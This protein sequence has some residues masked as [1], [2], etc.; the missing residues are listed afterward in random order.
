MYFRTL[1]TLLPAVN[2]FVRFL[3][4]CYS[5]SYFPCTPTFVEG[6]LWE[7][8]LSPSAPVPDVPDACPFL[9][10]M[11]VLSYLSYR[12]PTG[13]PFLPW[14]ACPFLSLSSPVLDACPF[15]PTGCPFLPWDACPFLSSPGLM[16]V[17][18][19]PRCLSFPT[20]LPLS[21]FPTPPVPTGAFLPVIALGSTS[22]RSCLKVIDRFR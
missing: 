21:Y 10:R 6:P 7:R 22:F 12:F 13:C 11:P 3:L 8:V 18:S 14:D 17:L 9:S 2:G 16:P 1:L 4:R 5:W 15:L 20:S 19:C